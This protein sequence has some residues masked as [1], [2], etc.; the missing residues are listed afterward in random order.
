ML[1]PPF[2]LRIGRYGDAVT[3]PV[4]RIFS[5]STLA[6]ALTLAATLGGCGPSDNDPGPGG[7]SVGEAQALDEAAEMIEA[8]RLPQLPPEEGASGDPEVEPETV[9]EPA[10]SE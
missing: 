1:L 7:V 3:C 2:S 9:G 10:P 6:A 8:K 5:V 4:Q